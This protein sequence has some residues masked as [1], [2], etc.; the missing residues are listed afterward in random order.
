[1]EHGVEQGGLALGAGQ[2]PAWVHALVVHVGHGVRVGAASHRF[3]VIDVGNDKN[4]EKNSE[5]TSEFI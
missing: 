4:Q 3:F 2:A 5:K 1:V